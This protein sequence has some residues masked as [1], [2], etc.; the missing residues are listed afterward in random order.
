MNNKLAR[1]VICL[2]L[3]GFLALGIEPL[4]AR[5]EESSACVCCVDVTAYSNLPDN[6]ISVKNDLGESKV[7][8]KVGKSKWKSVS[9]LERDEAGSYLIGTTAG[10]SV[11]VRVKKG[12]DVAGTNASFGIDTQGETRNGGM[13]PPYGFD[14][15]AFMNELFADGFTFTAEDGA[16]VVVELTKEN[17]GPGSSPVNN[18]KYY[19]YFDKNATVSKDGKTVTTK[20][21]S[22]EKIIITID[23]AKVE[24]GR[25]GI[26][27]DESKVVFYMGGDFNPKKMSVYVME[28]KENLT[29]DPMFIDLYIATGSNAVTLA[30]H[31]PEDGHFTNEMTFGIGG[32][33]SKTYTPSTPFPGPKSEVES[34]TSV[35]ESADEGLIYKLDKSGTATFMGTTSTASNLKVFSKL[36]VRGSV[37]KVTAINKNACKNNKKIKTLAVP[38]SVLKIGAGAFKGAS[39][40]KTVTLTPSS[41]LKLGTGAFDGINAS[42]K[43]KIVAKSSLYKKVRKK[44]LEA[45]MPE[46]ATFK[47]I[48]VPVGSVGNASDDSQSSA[49]TPVKPEPV[50]DPEIKME[51]FDI[52]FSVADIGSYS[53]W[54]G[55]SNI[56]YL[57]ERD[58][59]VVFS[60]DFGDMI[61][62][63]EG[64]GEAN[65]AR[66]DEGNEIWEQFASDPVCIQKEYSLYG[67][68]IRDDDGFFYMVTGHPGNEAGGQTGLIYVT[69][70]SPEGDIVGQVIDDGGSSLGFDAETKF[71]TFEP[72]Y[73]GNCVMSINNGIL[74][75]YYARKMV[76]GHQSDSLL[77]VNTEAMEEVFVGRVYQ[78]HS[79]A[80]RIVADGKGFL[81]ASEGDCYDR[82][83]VVT[84][85]NEKKETQSDAVFHFGIKPDT[86]NNSDVYTLNNNFAH[87]G[88]IAVSKSGKAVLAATSA[89]SMSEAA[90]DEPE[91]IFVQI[92]DRKKKLSSA[93][94]YVKGETR[95]GLSGG[96]GD[97]PCTDHGVIWLTNLKNSEKIG[98]LHCVIT[99]NDLVVLLYEKYDEKGTYL[100]VY[101]TILDLDGNVRHPETCYWERARISRSETPYCSGNTLWWIGNAEEDYCLYKYSLTVK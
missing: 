17:N 38:S 44:L 63:F 9:G 56:S 66:D 62:I 51:K 39:K 61:A 70:Y 87:L 78:S 72:F 20:G 79:F 55:V 74:A 83:F 69:K 84:S 86:L 41:K 35:K 36:R 13:R 8:Y 31:W 22:G 27:E 32:D 24:D 81:L 85:V 3:F 98:S 30:K 45:G 77:L 65:M 42:A 97:I 26:P 54:E 10:E 67:G 43:I 19:V 64:S 4:D 91:D 5:A 2:M 93:K 57:G 47:R 15:S 89:R 21:P 95:K 28:R 1:F 16:R 68:M 96:N 50:A 53:N 99:E 46:K 12:K 6:C 49:E 37:Y 90:Q 75:V 59:N 40:L 58:G 82:A 29:Y 52:D 100:G 14:H 60:V 48:D 7:Q 92:F 25:V 80:Q 33:P 71:L 18:P 73:S 34:T 101:Y 23:G 11:S 88:D 76:S 94:A